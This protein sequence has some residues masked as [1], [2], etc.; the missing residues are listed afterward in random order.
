MGPLEGVP[1]PAGVRDVRRAGTLG[2]SSGGYVSVSVLP[3]T[4]ETSEVVSQHGHSGRRAD[5]H[6]DEDFQMPVGVGAAVREGH[7]SQ[8]RG[9]GGGSFSLC[10]LQGGRTHKDKCEAKIATHTPLSPP[11]PAPGRSCFNPHPA[12]SHTLCWG[13][14]VVP[15]YRE[16]IQEQP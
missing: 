2:Q 14:G 9:Q 5:T 7:D 10:S 3:E 16:P 1:G 8:L 4:Q 12:G 13:K 15:D 11:P 6:G